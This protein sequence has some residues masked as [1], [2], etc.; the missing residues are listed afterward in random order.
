MSA[1]QHATSNNDRH[2]ARDHVWTHAI[3]LF[4]LARTAHDCVIYALLKTTCDTQDELWE[5]CDVE[6]ASF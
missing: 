3:R 4:H 1:T 2:E 6:V 5:F